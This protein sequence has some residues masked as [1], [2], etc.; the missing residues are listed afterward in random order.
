[1]KNC[2]IQKLNASVEQ[3]RFAQQQVASTTRNIVEQ[4]KLRDANN[5]L[6][7]SLNDMQELHQEAVDA[8][9]QELAKTCELYENK[10]AELKLRLKSQEIEFT[11]H[12]RSTEERMAELL[13]M[14]VQA[15][16]AE[17]APSKQNPVNPVDDID[18]DNGNVD[19]PKTSIDQNLLEEKLSALDKSHKEAHAVLKKTKTLRRKPG[20]STTNLKGSLKSKTK[21]NVA[22]LKSG[23][24]LKAKS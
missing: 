9:K 8:T 15:D 21:R 16:N 5:S 7:M 2:N 22:E 11:R 19:E 23:K 3:F 12:L 17:V 4:K 24:V 14:K 1:M 20:K 18:I 10:I 13:Q 6:R